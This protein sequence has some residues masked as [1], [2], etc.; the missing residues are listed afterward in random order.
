MNAIVESV[1]T[2][3]LEAE[4]VPPPRLK[5]YATLRFRLI[6]SVALVHA[7]L[8]GA[9]TWDAVTAQSDNLRA[10][11]Q[12]R[13]HALSS[14]MAVATTNAILAE[15]LASL[16]E[17]IDRTERQPDVSYAEVM[18][19]E[20]NVLASTDPSRVGRRAAPRIKVSETM[21][22][23][24]GDHTLDLREDIHVAGHDV[25]AVFVGMSTKNLDHELA[26]TRDAGLT[27]ILIALV[28]G[29]LA[30]WALSFATTR[31][32]H[33]MTTAV[34]RIAGGDL[35]VRVN[36]HS[37]DEVGL[38]ARA[39]NKMVSSLQ[40]TSRQVRLEHKKRTEAER[41]ACVGELSASIAHEIRNPLAAIINSV[42]LMAR[43][44]LPAEDQAQVAA[45]INAETDRLQRTLNDLL[46]FSRIPDS[47]MVETDVCQL[48]RDTMLLLSN[49][50][51]LP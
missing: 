43:G 18:D 4:A 35:D 50:P 37:A 32:L 40:R 11:L 48:L 28:V 51:A 42:R 22:L 30:A 2:T 34:R 9:F 41:L 39:F 14:L 8:M 5:W 46:T 24:P 23:A 15:N 36:I 25:G 21:P 27:F 49:D 33:L 45:I 3:M 19:A 16:A 1:P 7:V 38:L 47:K 17:V 26:A 44:D 12:S 6:L 10:E 13:G 29:S 20:G 31:N